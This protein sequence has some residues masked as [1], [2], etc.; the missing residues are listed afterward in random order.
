MARNLILYTMLGAL[1]NLCACSV[2][3]NQPSRTARIENARA[4]HVNGI[5]KNMLQQIVYI[6]VALLN[7]IF[8]I[9]Q[10]L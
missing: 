7:L 8:L 6:K 2:Q 1:L 4:T 5:I 9:I 10:F 3:T